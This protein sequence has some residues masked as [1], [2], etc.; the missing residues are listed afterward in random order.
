MGRVGAFLLR[1]LIKIPNFVEMSEKE[2]IEGF[3][4]YIFWDTDRFSINLNENAP[5]V[6]QRVLEYGQIND[7]KLMLS[8]YGL[9]RIV[10]ITKKL[11][12]LEP[13]ALSFICAISDTPKEQFRCYNSKL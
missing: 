13:K 5:Y 9:D 12:T 6:V 3:S 1:Y 10:E 8:Y 11:R 4:N 7:W 2:Y